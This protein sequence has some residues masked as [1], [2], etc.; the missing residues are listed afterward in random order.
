MEEA[1]D[2]LRTELSHLAEAN[3]TTQSLDRNVT[4]IQFQEEYVRKTADK[5]YFLDT[6]QEFMAVYYDS[7]SILCMLAP[8]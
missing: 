7:L 5:K 2:R 8:Q 1:I 3:V 6:L 4:L